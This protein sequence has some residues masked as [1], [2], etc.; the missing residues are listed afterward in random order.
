MPRPVRQ[1]K[2]NL[3]RLLMEAA[4]AKITKFGCR[5]FPPLLIKTVTPYPWHPN[6]NPA[7]D[8]LKSRCQY[9]DARVLIPELID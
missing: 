9:Y 6:F 7:L 1:L 4:Q 5:Y 3:Y 8:P 2:F